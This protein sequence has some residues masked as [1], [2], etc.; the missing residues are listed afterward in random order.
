M[1]SGDVTS[2]ALV[3]ESRG[4][5]AEIVSRHDAVVAGVGLGEL[6]F[7]ELDPAVQYRGCAADGDTVRPGQR[8]AFI[9][10]RARDLLAGER[11]ALNFMQRL[12]GIAT[13][14]RRFVDKVGAWPVMILDTRK[15]TPMFRA[16]EKYAVRC[17]GGENHRRGLYDRALIKDNHRR[18]WKGEGAG[19]LADAVTEVR[20]RFPDIAVEVEVESEEELLDVLRQKPEWVL[21]DNM[22]PDRLRNCV[23][24]CGKRCRLEASGGIT[25][26][27]VEA[28]A[29]TGVDA[30]SLG[31]LTHSAPAADLSLE[32]L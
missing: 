32:L 8:V 11:T 3:P 7:R 25:L 20:S 15:T 4:A 18:L 1:G 5:S 26:D 19:S 2:Q 10:G 28:V 24:L 22:P 16:L 9:E 27:T 31:C 23:R 13:L 6:V 21:L 17:G 12:S 29:A 14:T 30:I